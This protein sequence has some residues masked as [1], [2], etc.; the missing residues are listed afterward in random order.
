MKLVYNIKEKEKLV[1]LSLLRTLFFKS[2]VIC[3]TWNEVG[4]GIE[5]LSEV[6]LA[7]YGVSRFF[8]DFEKI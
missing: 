3:V 1:P 4:V 2:G 8:G 5:Y 7:D 6:R